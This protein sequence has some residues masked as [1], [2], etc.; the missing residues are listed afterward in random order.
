LAFPIILTIA[1]ML[2]ILVN[3]CRIYTVAIVQNYSIH[4]MA[5][6]QAILHEA[7]GIVTHLSFL[8]ISYYFIEKLLLKT[9]Q[10]NAHL[11]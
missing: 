6:D 3:T 2:T 9:Q 1:Y 5:F 11:S 10:Q 4:W 8:L 7:I